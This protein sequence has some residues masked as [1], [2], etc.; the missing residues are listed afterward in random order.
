MDRNGSF[1]GQISRRKLLVGGV[2]FAAAGATGLSSSFGQE[3]PAREVKI[4]VPTT[5]GGVFD[6]AARLLADHMKAQLSVPVI[7]ENRPGAAAL[8]GP[9]AVARSPADGYTICLCSSGALTLSGL[10]GPQPNY[11]PLKDFDAVNLSFWLTLVLAAR[12]GLPVD[13]IPDLVKYAAANPG[14]V[15]IGYAGNAGLISAALLK[16][17]VGLQLREVPYQGEAQGLTDVAGQ[18]IDLFPASVV[19]AKSLVESGGIKLLAALTSRR[20][21]IWPNV[22]TVAEQGFAGFAVDTFVGLNVP[23]GTPKP[24]VD[25]LAAAAE[26]A[27]KSSALRE[28]FDQLGLS[29][30]GV[31]PADYQQIIVTERAKWTT[32]V[33]QAGPPK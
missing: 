8:L 3:Y 1:D 6:T 21:A 9:Q 19:T 30:A 28:K 11:D 15:T 20:A 23:K 17:V 12:K 10:L 22:P 4:I 27:A 16:K 24:V 33:E 13:N 2:A 14:K 5:A 18:V 32:L 31:G 29:P 7:I 25:R 26:A